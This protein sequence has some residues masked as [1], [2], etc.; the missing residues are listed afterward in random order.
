MSDREFSAPNVSTW[1]DLKA[2]T[3]LLERY[4][5]WV[6]WRMVNGAVDVGEAELLADLDALIA[7]RPLEPRPHWVTTDEEARERLH[8]ESS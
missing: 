3:A 2:K 6:R 1:D 5:G 7:G 4:C 8:G